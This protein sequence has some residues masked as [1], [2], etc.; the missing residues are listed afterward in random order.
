MTEIQKDNKNI[1][2]CALCDEQDAVLKES[3]IIPKFAYDWI[4]ETSPTP[5]LR[6]TENVN[7][8][9]QD[10]PKQYLLCGKCEG[11]LAAMEK[12]LAENLFKK[13]ANYRTQMAQIE[14]TNTMRVGVLSIF[15]RTLLT[16]GNRSNDRTAEDNVARAAFLKSAKDQ[17][18]QREATMPIYIVPMYG[19][20]PFYG[21]PDSATYLLHRQVGAADILFRDNPHRYF[22]VFKL[23]FIFF[24]IPSEGWS[25]ES[26]QHSL[27]LGTAKL[28]AISHIPDYLRE[29]ILKL[30]NQFELL[31][32]DLSEKSRNTIARDV[33]KVTRETG[34]HKSLAMSRPEKH[35]STKG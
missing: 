18:L 31:K 10:G 34:A 21:F 1:G 23:P 9:E 35:R 22:A 4:K 17:I 2:T 33:G 7:T 14:I 28:D 11:N 26:D 8:R 6:T 5:Y 29:Y 15:W 16:Q 30:I 12:E 13:I 19:P 25:E 3:H 24:Y 20:S 32:Q 27:F